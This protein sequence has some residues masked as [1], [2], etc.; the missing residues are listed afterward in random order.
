M[1]TDT[2]SG[3][4]TGTSSSSQTGSESNSATGTS[5]GSVTGTSS[6]SQIMISHM[7]D[8]M[9]N[10]SFFNTVYGSGE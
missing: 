8:Q 6:V 2:P 5:S 10:Y 3:S 4:V 7:P 1:N 9:K